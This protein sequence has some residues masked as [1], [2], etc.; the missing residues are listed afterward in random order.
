MRGVAEIPRGLRQA[1]EPDVGGQ[2]RADGLQQHFVEP[3]PT[4]VLALGDTTRVERRVR[5]VLIDV[6]ERVTHPPV[7]V[8]RPAARGYSRKSQRMGRADE[9]HGAL[10]VAQKG[11]RLEQP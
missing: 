11:C 9:R 2:R 7:N 10:L 3:A 4:Y 8:V 5:Q 6:F 1:P